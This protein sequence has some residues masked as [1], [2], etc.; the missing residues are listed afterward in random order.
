MLRRLKST[1]LDLTPT[2][3][4]PAA[5]GRVVPHS[6]RSERRRNYILQRVGAWAGEPVRPGFNSSLTSSM[7]KEEENQAISLNF[8]L[9]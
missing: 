8:Y 6:L 1:V 4:S 2:P 7:T 5:H 3:K 9:L